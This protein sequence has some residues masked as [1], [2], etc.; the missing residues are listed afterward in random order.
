RWRRRGCLLLLRKG[1]R[2]GTQRDRPKKPYKGC[3]SREHGGATNGRRPEPRSLPDFRRRFV[4]GGRKKWLKAEGLAPASPKPSAL[5]PVLRQ[6]TAGRQFSGR[7]VRELA[8]VEIDVDVAPAQVTT[9]QFLRERIL[10]VPLDRAPQRPRPVRAILARDL[11]DPI[12]HFGRE[13]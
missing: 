6:L 2:C 9:D 13:R 5:S 12:H 11:D 3:Y 7:T 8:C 1:R 10:D 4:A